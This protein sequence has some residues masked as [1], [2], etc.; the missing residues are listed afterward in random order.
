MLDRI[1]KVK[2]QRRLGVGRRDGR[3]LDELGGGRAEQPGRAGVLGRDRYHPFFGGTRV[4]P[5][6]GGSHRLR[7]R[8]HQHRCRSR[9][10]RLRLHG[11]EREQERFAGHGRRDLRCILRIL[12]L[13]LHRFNR[14]PYGGGK[15]PFRFHVDHLQLDRDDLALRVGLLRVPAQEQD[16][17]GED[18][19]DADGPGR[20]W[21]ADR[22]PARCRAGGPSR[23]PARDGSARDGRRGGERQPCVGPGGL[24]AL[25]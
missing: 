22:G 6:L 17:G 9:D 19:E 24:L 25:S 10:L 21:T 13:H 15:R 4:C 2:V 3:L 20:L 23:R 5:L 18:G 12:A 1:E 14:G 16:P 7:V 11:L 8:L